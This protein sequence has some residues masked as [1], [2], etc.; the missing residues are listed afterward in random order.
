[1]IKVYEDIK[2]RFSIDPKKDTFVY[3]APTKEAAAAVAKRYSTKKTPLR[4]YKGNQLFF[5]IVKKNIFYI[6]R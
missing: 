5:A 4:A 3:V 6:V 1:M 2:N